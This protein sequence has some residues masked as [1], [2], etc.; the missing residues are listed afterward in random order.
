MG[1]LLEKSL[2][3]NLGKFEKY[4]SMKLEIPDLIFFLFL[5]LL[6]LLFFLV[7]FFFLLFQLAPAGQKGFRLWHRAQQ[8]NGQRPILRRQGWHRSGRAG[9]RLP[10]FAVLQDGLLQL[11]WAIVGE[12][13]LISL[14]CRILYT[15]KSGSTDSCE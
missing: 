10:V 4:D 9:A 3:K 14:W 1:D 11:A 12:S 6:L 2:G 13:L 5:H 8:P 7:L 15:P